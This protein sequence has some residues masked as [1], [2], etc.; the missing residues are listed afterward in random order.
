MLR[1]AIVLAVLAAVSLLACGDDTVDVASADASTDREP[2][3]DG[4]LAVDAGPEG[5][6][7]AD[8]S[9]FADVFGGGDAA[10]DASGSDGVAP[11]DGASFDAGAFD[12]GPEAGDGATGC[13][14]VDDGAFTIPAGKVCTAD[15]W[16][17]ENALP[18]GNSLFGVWG[19]SP[20]EVWAVG[21]M[22]TIL[23]YD[24]N[25]WSGVALGPVD[26]NVPTPEGEAYTAYSFIGVRGSAAND[27]WVV[28]NAGRALHFDGSA[29]TAKPTCEP[30]VDLVAVSPLGPADAWAVGWSGPGPADAAIGAI[31]HWDG[32][33]WTR[34]ETGASLGGVSLSAVWARADDDV[35]A[36][37]TRQDI[38]D[39]LGMV[40]HWDGQT[41]TMVESQYG[42]GFASLW[43]SADG[44][45]WVAGSDEGAAA[46]DHFDGTSWTLAI[47]DTATEYLLGL[48]GTSATDIWAAGY[49]ESSLWHW[50]GAAWSGQ[51][52]DGSLTSVWTAGG[53]TGW[54]VGAWGQMVEWNG[55]S[56]SSQAVI[57]TSLTGVWGAAPN[58]VWM[59]GQTG[60]LSAADVPSG[61]VLHWDGYALSQ[62]ATFDG[63]VPSQVWGSA[64]DDVWAV[65][66]AG[67]IAHRTPSAWTAVASGSEADLASVHGSGPT[68][69]WA[70]GVSGTI[71]H[72]D[73]AS[74]SPSAAPSGTT[75]TLL[76]V[77]SMSPTDA[78]VVGQAGTVLRWDGA[79]WNAVDAGVTTPLY[80]VW[81]SSDDDVWIGGENTALHFDG[82]T[83]TLL[84]MPFGSIFSVLGSGPN[85]V[86]VGGDIVGHWDGS[87]WTF[88]NSATSP[89]SQTRPWGFWEGGGE[90]WLVGEGGL[91]VH[92][93]PRGG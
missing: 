53:S 22:G 82:A 56:A 10:V 69:M 85:D 70:V 92:R 6:G 25:A 68:D 73:G 55:A 26:G 54:A 59:V 61:D 76:H 75:N 93:M 1:S 17:W 34:E 42:V 51:S 38:G 71:L 43:G 84:D 37:G 57:A 30:A 31:L 41:W 89:I 7:S 90:A 3:V 27:V 33:A 40:L 9:A 11:A 62:D 46:V 66:N 91:A 87:T 29:W 60:G 77:F 8:G 83:W 13:G 32:A 48:S 36:A 2:D 45:L 20:R 52:I 18:Q 5:G 49:P 63:V 12:A 47:V 72:Y 39:H 16:C 35:W 86:W 80:G 23:S 21:P 65:G 14:V 24:G 88:E 78:W 50:D 44:E 4:S 81:A 58:D 67:W 64:S 15:R 19:A 74:W 79:A 28:G